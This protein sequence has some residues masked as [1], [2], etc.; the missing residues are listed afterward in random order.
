MVGNKTIQHFNNIA[1]NYKEEVPGHIRDHLINRLWSLA[2]H[3][4]SKNCKVLDI[5]C[6]DGTN[7]AF[8]RSKGVNAIGVDMSEKLLARG[9]ERYPYLRNVI[10]PGDALNLQFQDNTF[11]IATMIGILHHVHSESEQITAIHEAIRVVKNNGAV[12]IRESNLINPLFR[13]FWNYV[14]PL[15]AKIDRFGG[16]NWVSIKYLSDLFDETIDKTI[17][18][19]FIP[20]FMPKLLIPLAGRI[21]K[22]LENSPIKKM[23]AHYMVVLRKRKNH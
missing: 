13:I 4:F 21:E 20:S 3:Y 17:Y 6:G 19:T 8:F 22:F 5:G 12:I 14:F 10:F 23:S 18:F 11:D 15:T 7:I 9:K 1:E 2:S 16:E